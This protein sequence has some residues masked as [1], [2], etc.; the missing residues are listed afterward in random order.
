M[1]PQ[2]EVVLEPDWWA[3]YTEKDVPQ[4]WVN[5]HFMAVYDQASPDK[6]DV[7]KMAVGVLRE[8]NTRKRTAKFD[9]LI[10]AL[11]YQDVYIDVTPQQLFFGGQKY[12][13]I[14]MAAVM[15]VFTP[16]G[17]YSRGYQ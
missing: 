3:K 4:S 2:R 6:Q 8:P 5:P 11:E 1:F 15:E 17:I 12:M 10:K 16:T 13:K 7:A 14:L 9:V